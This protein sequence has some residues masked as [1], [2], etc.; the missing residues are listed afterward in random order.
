MQKNHLTL[1]NIKNF[2]NKDKSAFDDKDKK[3]SFMD[4]KKADI[5]EEIGKKLIEEKKHLEE[6]LI[7]IIKDLD[8]RKL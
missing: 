5:K 8:M 6:Q 7:Y 3:L 2:N 1:N 4:E